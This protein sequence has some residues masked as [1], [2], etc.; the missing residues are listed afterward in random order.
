MILNYDQ[1]NGFSS[2]FSKFVN[3][4]KKTVEISQEVRD[5][6]SKL[7]G[8]E[9]ALKIGSAEDAYEYAQGLGVANKAVVDFVREGKGGLKEYEAAM[10]S[11]SKSTT[12]FSMAISGLKS[13]GAGIIN[14]LASY[15]ISFI[16]GK[17]I[18]GIYNIINATEIA[19]EKGKEAQ[20]AIAGAFDEF[21]NTKSSIIEIG[22][23]VSSDSSISTAED[24]I[25]AI[26]ERYAYL[27]KGIGDNNENIALSS[28]NYQEYLN[29]NK[30][31][32]DQFPTLISG[33]DEQGNAILNLGN[34][35]SNAADQMMELYNASMLSANVEIGNNLQDATNGVIA[36]VEAAAE[37]E[38][39]LIEQNSNI[40]EEINKLNDK[41]KDIFTFGNGGF[42]VKSTDADKVEEILKNNGIDLKDVARRPNGT[43]YTYYSDAISKMTLQEISGLNDQWNNAVDDYVSKN[44]NILEAE[45]LQNNQSISANKLLI[46]DQWKSIY[47][48]IGKYLQTSATFNG[49]DVGLQNALIN[50][51]KNIDTDKL[52]QEY[53]GK[54]IPFI[55]GEYLGPINDLKPEAQE[56]LTNLFKL[57]TSEMSLQEYSNKFHDVL[58][59]ISDDPTIQKEWSDKIGFSTIFGE[60]YNKSN[61]LMQ[62]FK[63]Y[64]KE[65]SDLKLSDLDLMYS[66][67]SEDPTLTWDKL[68]FK[69]NEYKNA[70]SEVPSDTKFSSLFGENSEIT[71]KVDDFQS[72]ISSIQS[73]LE[74]LKSGDYTPSDITDLIQKFPSL[75]T[76][77]DNLNSALNGL[78]V[79][80][81]VS[82]MNA[83]RDAMQGVT[84]PTQLAAMNAFSENLKKEF[85]GGLDANAINNADIKETLRS[86]FPDTKDIYG[87]REEYQKNINQLIS[88]FG[89]TE[90]GRAALLTL[91]AAIEIDPSLA[92]VDYDTL[93]SYV[94]SDE[95]L[96]KIVFADENII[97]LQNE[98]KYLQDDANAIQDN[99]NLKEAANIKVSKSDYLALIKNGNDQIKNLEQTIQEFEN[100][101]EGLSE[102]SDEWKSIQSEIDATNSSINEVIISQLEWNN[103]IANLPISNVQ[104]LTSAISAAYDETNSVTGLTNDTMNSLL[105]QFSD[106]SGMDTSTLFYRSADGVKVNT[107]ELQ[108]FAK[109]EDKIVRNNFK[110]EIQKQE[111][112]IKSY[113]AQIGDGKTDS[114]LQSMENNLQ[115]LLNQRAQ[116]FAEYKKQMEEFSKFN[117]IAIAEGTENQGAKYDKMQSRL[118]SWKEMYDKG[119]TGTDDF[120]SMGEYFNK[121]GFGDVDS[122]TSDYKMASRYLTEDATGVQNFFSDLQTKGLA[123]LQTL[124][125]GSEAL[126]MN[127]NSAAEAAFTMGMGEEFFTDM[128]GKSEEYG[129]GVTFITSI[130][131]S[132]L[133]TEE[134]NQK[135]VEAQK[136]YT[137]LKNMGADDAALQKQQGVIDD[138]KT[139]VS[140]VE[141]VTQNYIANEK[142]QYADGFENIKS[143]ISDFAQYRNEALARGDYQGALQFEEEAKQL[144]QEYGVDIVI[145][146]DNITVDKD[147]F[148]EKLQE[149]YP[150]IGTWEKPVLP[151]L[152][153]GN[154][155][156]YSDVLRT[157]RNGH[158]DGNEVLESNLDI[159]KQCTAEELKSLKLS[160]GMYDFDEGK[161]R[162]A[163]MA[164]DAITK[165]FG[166]TVD[167][168]KLLPNVLEAVGQTKYEFPSAENK[169][170]WE[171]PIKPADIEDVESYTSAFG[172]VKQAYEDGNPAIEDATSVLSKYTAA[173]LRSINVN[174]EKYTPGLEEAEMA[175]DSLASALGLTKEEAQMLA[176]VLEAFGQTK[177]EPEISG[178]DG[179]TYYNGLTELQQ[180]QSEGK[181]SVKCDFTAD[182]SG[183]ELDELEKRLESLETIK[184]ELDIEPGSDAE[185]TIDA[186]IED[187]NLQIK[188]NTVL[189]ENPD[190]DALLQMDDD[191]LI[192]LGVSADQLDG[193]KQKLEEIKAN[194]EI[195]VT[196][197]IDDDQFEAL[198]TN[199]TTANF[200]ATEANSKISE[201]KENLDSIP[202]TAPDPATKIAVDNSNANKK[203]ED[204]KQKLQALNSIT[205]KPTINISNSLA[206]SQINTIRDKL[207]ELDNKTVTSYIKTVHQNVGS[208]NKVGELNGTAHASGTA[209]AGGNWGKKTSGTTLVG[210]LGPE[211]VVDPYT[212]NWRMVGEF[213]AEFTDIKKGSIVFNHKQTAALLKNGYTTTR[214]KALAGG[215]A[216]LQGTAYSKGTGKVTLPSTSKASPSS[217]SS[218]TTTAT[219]QNTAAVNAN[220]TE[221]KKSTSTT[222]KTTSS[223]VKSF[224]G[225]KKWIEKLMD[226]VAVRLERLQQQI[227]L[228]LAK[229]DNAVGYER[230]NVL[231]SAAQ[232]NT[233]DLISD[234]E[235]GAAK[236]QAQ[237][238]KVMAQAVNAKMLNGKTKSA[239]TKRAND[240]IKLIKSGD[241]KISEY[242]EKE[243]EFINQYTEWY[244]K[245]VECKQ[246]VEDLKK[247]QRELERQKFDNIANEYENI[248]SLQEAM[249]ESISKERELRET[250]GFDPTEEDYYKEINGLMSNRIHLENER[251]RLENQLKSSLKSGEVVVGDENWYEM[252]TQIIDVGNEIKDV[253]INIIDLNNELDNL[254]L[255]R[256]EKMADLLDSIT[257]YLSKKMDFTTASGK[258]NTFDELN[259]TI[260]ATY[261]QYLN[262]NER[263]WENQQKM[264]AAQNSGGAAFGHDTAYWEAA[265]YDALSEGQGYL[266]DILDLQKQM[267]ELPLQKLTDQMN[268][269]KSVIEVITSEADLKEAQGH[270]LTTAD[271]QRQLA[272]TNEEIAKQEAINA[273][274]QWLYLNALARDAEDE[275]AEYFDAWKSSEAELNNMKST[276]EELS[277][278][279]RDDF[280]ESVKRAISAIDDI[281]SV[282]ESQ[283]NIKNSAG[284]YLDASDYEKQMALNTQEFQSQQKIIADRYAKYNEALIAKNE[285]EADQMLSE[286]R[287]AEAAANDLLAANEELQKSIQ[288]LFRDTIQRELDA[289]DAAQRVLESQISLKEA[290]SRDLTRSDYNSQIDGNMQLILKQQAL[291]REN[292][293][294]Y[295]LEVSKGN[296]A[297]AAEYLQAWK[298]AEAEV[299][300]LRS[301]IENL[302]DEMRKALLTKELDDLLDKL[303]QLRASMSTISGIISDDMMYG[304]DGNL[305]DFGVTALAMNIKTYESN[306]ES[307]KALLE[308]RQKYI[309]EYNNGMNEYYSRNE[310]DEDMKD[311]TSEIQSMLT[312]TNSARQAIVEMILKTSEMEIDALNDVIDKRKELLQAQKDAYDFDKTLKSQT[313]DLTL[314]QKQAQ[315]LEGLTD[316][317]S[318]AKLQKLNKQIAEAQETLNETITDHSFDLKIDGLDDLKNEISDAYDKYVKELNANLDAITSAVT[319][320]TGT[321]VGALGTVEEAIM[322]LLNSYG[323]SGLNTETI[324]YTRQYAKGTKY[325]KEDEWAITQEN[326]QEVIVHPDGSM[327]TPLKQGSSVINNPMTEKLLSLAS[328]YDAIK[329][330][331]ETTNKM[332]NAKQAANV[333]ATEKR[334]VESQ[335]VRTE[336][337]SPSVNV[338]SIEIVITDPVDSN[339]VMDVIN[340]NI[341]TIAGNVGKEFSKNINKAGTRKS[342]G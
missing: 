18:E 68:I 16:A 295:N 212:A 169:A 59:T 196:V 72:N 342:W 143:T 184:T 244:N 336:T 340:K 111:A 123:T 240:I 282:V 299:N 98:L 211:I 207:N 311:I 11:A 52:V 321:V 157:I 26:A 54:I 117:A 186:L 294:L 300:N 266:I 86:L 101:R 174:D 335:I 277:D 173:E 14:A 290:Q 45:K 219:K 77:T 250:I 187:T 38:A 178:I 118:K 171:N 243:R 182:T 292:Q 166:L 85:I 235:K 13:I 293:R 6:F 60:E 43:M 201:Y 106:L 42:S 341:K 318:Q 204:T 241:I 200:D 5:A 315:A 84:D 58:K 142:Q 87:Y 139:Q 210:E 134:L 291:A 121:Y 92:Y 289:L 220:T 303:E 91:S 8:N 146:S 218:N 268:N 27:K 12:G 3:D 227:D 29:I 231:V 194:A 93:K 119:L 281:R 152:G 325:V 284:K 108:K 35:A 50:S 209:L 103:A 302:G 287:Q 39:K 161:L 82:A 338:G 332:F 309:E 81:F 254:N 197:K 99:I 148:N 71:K 10:Q 331:V 61:T 257:G 214:G 172:K 234:N 120:E 22:V 298:D 199:T 253:D 216:L 73:A 276:V 107:G 125:D 305:T 208:G 36:Q 278:K 88:E 223:L 323:V 40:D 247:S 283:I 74:K 80:N 33:Y 67:Y 155:E 4:G 153:T 110:S 145:T 56:A 237:A 41:N 222:S 261:D 115:K 76:E 32:A 44:Q 62:K 114:K 274:N 132:I 192:E 167:Q 9:N 242:G 175:L 228:N 193:F 53:E 176:T 190:I 324:G 264:W 162:D 131:D 203:I 55:Y 100:K 226:W 129:A 113:Q 252:Q 102:T 319:D 316:K 221:T 25:N 70:V 206:N 308:K 198:T 189:E 230:K 236:Y 160:D 232:K 307:L 170:N 301:T 109:Q 37:T 326:G 79:D 270:Y 21:K 224:D 334:I 15:A 317:E 188:V 239:R 156:T 256:L 126:I 168:A 124:S 95:I 135:I 279:I 165:E 337:Q 259:D 202:E 233:A 229:A 1:K 65:I 63:D 181:F 66:F 49:L 339:N 20:E 163:E 64:A 19:I 46:Q 133:Q 31:I 267:R 310:F 122:F 313:N 225:F 269:L 258:Y 159:L 251:I 140:D 34:N 280:V 127:F 48:N 24:S 273:N 333:A 2:I 320:A 51:L 104:A 105:T 154:Q 255:T 28:D 262:A 130:E 215:S 213:G 150:G 30:Q 275:A 94:E 195:P 322:K 260:N 263:A 327:L 245:A 137:E 272:A 265:Y 151:S 158:K 285:A 112:A 306:T 47:S 89:G 177:V 116:Y 297:S 138:L 286:A 314:L 271:Y 17:L 97:D 90:E 249:N 329:D 191:E 23:S 136:K 147:S 205:A 128:L 57:D 246:A 217:S 328:N 78:A 7:E 238:D 296:F 183:M 304:E 330:M 288:N 96:A 185:A 179:E 144:G 69:V 164:L 248:L 312:S 180:M 141:E 75:S 149:L 83:I